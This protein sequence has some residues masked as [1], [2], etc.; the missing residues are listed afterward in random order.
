MTSVTLWSGYYIGNSKFSDK[1]LILS[2]LLQYATGKFLSSVFP[3]FMPLSKPLWTPSFVLITNSISIFKGML[4][5]KCLAYAPAIVANS[6]AAVGRQSLEVYFIGE[7][8]FLLLKF[9]NGAGTSIWNMAEHL[10]TKYM[11]ANLANAALL[12]LFDMFL[13]GSALACS[14]WN[15]RL[16]L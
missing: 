4:L 5:K 1:A 13:V 15:L 6:L 7:I 9:N 3:R 12:V 2:G 14:K 11:P 8:T 16:R 10:L